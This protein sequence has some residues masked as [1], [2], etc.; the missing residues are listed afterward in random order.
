[1][2]EDDHWLNL[3]EDEDENE[4]AHLCFMVKREEI[5]SDEVDDARSID[6]ESTS[7][8][9]FESISGF[10]EHLQSLMV[11]VIKTEKQLKNERKTVKSL[12]GKFKNERDQFLKLLIEKAETDDE[13]IYLQKCLNK[14]KEENEEL[15]LV[16]PV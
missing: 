16:H 9:K 4:E 13:V 8:V 11:R 12:E 3:T 2:A 1:M 7:K 10:N 5:N 14:L 15:L 6:S